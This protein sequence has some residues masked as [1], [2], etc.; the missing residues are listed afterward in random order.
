[1]TT[2]RGTWNAGALYLPG[3]ETGY[4]GTVWV[5]LTTS[6]GQVPSPGAYWVPE[7]VLSGPE[8]PATTTD[9]G[10][11]QLAGDLAGTAM[12]PTVAKI[13]GTVIGAPPGVSSQFLAGDGS[14]QAPAASES[15][16]PVQI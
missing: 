9:E 2:W 8:P 10:V 14:W 5:A 6:T 13:Q 11:I 15:Y 3:D 12:A 16:A 1:V 7:P 4:G